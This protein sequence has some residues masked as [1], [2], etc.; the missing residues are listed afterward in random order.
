M[1]IMW[2]SASFAARLSKLVVDGTTPPSP[3]IRSIAS[4]NGA[5]RPS[6]RQPRTATF[7]TSYRARSRVVSVTSGSASSAWDG[8]CSSSSESNAARI[9]LASNSSVLTLWPCGF[10]PL[11]GRAAMPCSLPQEPVDGRCTIRAAPAQR[12]V[13]ELAQHRAARRPETSRLSIDL[14]QE[15]VR[16]RHHNLR[17]TRSIPWYTIEAQ[18]HIDQPIPGPT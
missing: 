5:T 4:S 17:H 10:H 15:I 2:S 3:E 7:A 8:P 18:L 11:C 1:E 12:G 13:G 14:A 9:T 16:H 6:S